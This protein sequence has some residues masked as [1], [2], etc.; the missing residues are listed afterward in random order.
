MP[1]PKR[2]FNLSGWLLVTARSVLP[3]RLKS[4]G[5]I[6]L[7]KFPALT[8]DPR[9]WEKLPSPFPKRME[10][11]ALLSFEKARSGLP[12]PLKFATTTKVGRCT[13]VIGEPGAWAKLAPQPAGCCIGEDIEGAMGSLKSAGIAGSASGKKST[14]FFNSTVGNNCGAVGKLSELTPLLKAVKLKPITVSAKT[15]QP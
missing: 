14:S 15:N 1:F 5:A 11:L 13:E 6:N 8:G 9:A 2:I 7:G 3:S 4:P 10:T 12:S